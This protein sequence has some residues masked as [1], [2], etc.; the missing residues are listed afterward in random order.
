MRTLV[1]TVLIAATV[2]C[3]QSENGPR[4]ESG[5]ALPEPVY[6][7]DGGAVTNEITVEF[8]EGVAEDRVS[9]LVDSLSEALGAAVITTQ[10]ATYTEYTLRWSPDR[11]LDRDSIMASVRAMPDILTVGPTVVISPH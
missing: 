10:S 2:S 6:D 4:S 3:C 8:R 9:A 5:D 1:V 7:Q 11:E